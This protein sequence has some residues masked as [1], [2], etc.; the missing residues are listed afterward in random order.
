MY[1]CVGGSVSS[2]ESEQLPVCICVLG[3]LYQAMKVSSYLYV[4][5]LGESVSSYENEQLP[6][7]ICVLAGLYQ[8]MKGGRYLY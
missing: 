5:V 1:M 6:V 3:G 7:C 4:Y 8:G 2:Y